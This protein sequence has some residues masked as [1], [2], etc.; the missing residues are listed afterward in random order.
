MDCSREIPAVLRA[1]AITLEQLQAVVPTTQLS[2]ANAKEPAR[3]P[4]L[5]YK[6]YSPHARVEIVAD[7]ERFNPLT[8]AAFIGLHPPAEAVAFKRLQLCRNV[9]EYAH[10]LFSFF[11]ACD[12]AGVQ[13]IY[14]EVVSETGL[15]L[16]LMDRIKRAAHG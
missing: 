14:C 9:E 8:D 3:S 4:G 11:R 1:G 10:L 16:A 15:G 12:E 7:F 13:V 6:H 2:Q 5:K